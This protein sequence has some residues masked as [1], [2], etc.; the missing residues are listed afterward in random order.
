MAAC[1]SSDVGSS[2]KDVSDSVSDR[3]LVANNA[4]AANDAGRSDKGSAGEDMEACLWPLW[5]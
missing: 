1:D 3:F 5:S 4:E 2:V